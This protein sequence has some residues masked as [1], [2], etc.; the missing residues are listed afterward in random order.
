M[1]STCKCKKCSS[2]FIVCNRLHWKQQ[3]LHADSPEEEEEE[4]KNGE[5]LSDVQSSIPER[6]GAKKRTV[7]EVWRTVLR[8]IDSGLFVV[9]ALVYLLML[10]EWLPEDY[11]TKQRS[12]KVLVKG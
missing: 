6:G 10:C 8:L 7:A 5:D 3:P 11:L 9:L 12:D 2:I 4:T 1:S